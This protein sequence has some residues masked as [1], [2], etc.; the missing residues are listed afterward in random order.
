MRPPDTRQAILAGLL[1]LIGFLLFRGLD[2]IEPAP[3]ATHGSR[4][5]TDMPFQYTGKARPVRVASSGWEGER[6]WSGYVDWEPVV[7]AEPEGDRVY[8]MAIR[9]YADACEGCPDPIVV[10]RS[11]RDGGLTWGPDRYPF[12]SGRTHAD[13]QLAVTREG[14]L[15]AAFLQD[16]DPGVVVARSDDGG[17]SWG[18]PVPVAPE[19]LPGGSDHPFLFV[20]ADGRD[21]YV[22]LNAS[23]SWVAVS[24]DGGATFEA[25]VRTDRDSRQWFHTGG[26]V[27]AD[28]TVLV[29]AVDYTPDYRGRSNINVLRSVDGGATWESRLVDR[30]EEPPGCE[31]IPG[32]YLGFLGP[33]ASLAAAPDG[34]LMLVYNAGA[35]AG[36]SQ[37]L[38]YR[39]SRD[40]AEWSER[41]PVVLPESGVSHAFPVIV[42]GG[43]PGRFHVF[44]QDDRGG[45]WNTWQ[46]RTDDGGASWVPRA[47]LSWAG[48]PASYKQGDGYDFPYG[49]YFGAAL[50]GGGRLHAIWGA[51]ESWS[52]N[53]GAWYTRKT[54]R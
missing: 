4:V 45:A 32:C 21:V 14:V 6:P 43:E 19:S 3:P 44:W 1:V 20:S 7:A 34:E 29:A 35:I 33:R 12:R 52:G 50:D 37:A 26:V 13:P 41:R 38:W 11:S 42:A 53:G 25:P 39:T 54:P 22:A 28:G 51:G 8:Q 40:G 46:R 17:R 47:R 23:A 5:R 2:P 49:D 15:F 16:H 18:Q 9:F 31:E 48:P 30:S 10:F 27:L 36:G 24:H